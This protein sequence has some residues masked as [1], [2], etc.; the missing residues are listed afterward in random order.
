MTWGWDLMLVQT[1]FRGYRGGNWRAIWKSTSNLSLGPW[2]LHFY[3]LSTL[4]KAAPELILSEERIYCRVNNNVEF[5][6]L[7]RT[8]LLGRLD[9]SVDW[10]PCARQELGDIYI[11]VHWI[12]MTPQSRGTPNRDKCHLSCAHTQ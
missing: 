7:V 6:R 9:Q 3:I 12:V 10:T 11:R 5:W 4:D 2:S 1:H 8:I